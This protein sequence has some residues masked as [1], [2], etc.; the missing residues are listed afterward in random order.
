MK[1]F[2]QSA[3][4]VPPLQRPAGITEC[5]PEDPASSCLSESLHSAPVG[6]DRAAPP[7][8]FLGDFL[9]SLSATEGWT[10]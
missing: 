7:V 5:S 9:L 2:F 4:D 6:G 1:R 10:P 3:L 8:S